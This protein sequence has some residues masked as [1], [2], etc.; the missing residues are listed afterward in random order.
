MISRTHLKRHGVFHTPEGR[1]LN[2]AGDE[3]QLVLR[4]LLFQP[5]TSPYWVEGRKNGSLNV[6]VSSRSGDIQVA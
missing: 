6:E 3:A 1:H 4:L 2:R 5:K